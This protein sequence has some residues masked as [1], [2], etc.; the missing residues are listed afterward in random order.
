MFNTKEKYLPCIKETFDL[1]GMANNHMMD[2]EKSG[3]FS[4]LEALDRHGIPHVGAGRNKE[5][6]WNFQ[7]VENF[8]IF[9]VS[10]ICVNEHYDLQCDEVAVLKKTDLI[11]DTINRIKADHPEKI[12]TIFPHW[13]KEYDPFALGL[14]K[15]KGHELID[16]GVDLVVGSH[17]HV[18]QEFEF[19]KGRPIIYS[20]GNAV[21][22]QKWSQAS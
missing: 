6:A 1:V 11:Q 13:G 17:P 15:A 12:I 9:A 2:Q 4:T 5:D 19:Y 20:L 14:I 22:D 21:L 8:A 18:V 7:I 10:F 3:L 16:M